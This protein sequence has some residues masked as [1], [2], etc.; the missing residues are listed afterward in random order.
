MTSRITLV[1]RPLECE[2][3]P[4]SGRADVWAA[5]ELLEPIHLWRHGEDLTVLGPDQLPTTFMRQPVMSQAQKREVI[6]VCRSASD[7]VH[8]MVS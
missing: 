4:T 5:S 1:T 3:G 2:T 7:P 6:Q 8:K